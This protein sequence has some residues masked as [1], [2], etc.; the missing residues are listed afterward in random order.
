MRSESSEDQ[1][2]V[3]PLR[4]R[5]TSKLSVAPLAITDL[6][7][8]ALIGIEPRVFREWLVSA[9]VPFI[10]IGRRVIARADHVL[11]ALAGDA[12]STATP[13]DVEDDDSQPTSEAEVLAAIGLRRAS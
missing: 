3:R 12:A 11:A 7:C 10:R 1:K 9:A 8:A 4:T 13:G 5:E 2:Q 6:T